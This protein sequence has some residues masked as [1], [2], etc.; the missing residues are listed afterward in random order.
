MVL[1]FAAG[2]P[3]FETLPLLT[4]PPGS[5]PDQPVATGKW[6]ATISKARIDITTPN[7]PKVV[8]LQL[9]TSLDEPYRTESERTVQTQSVSDKSFVTSDGLT[10]PGSEGCFRVYAVTATDNEAGSVTLIIKRPA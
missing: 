5:T 2:T 3:L 4:P 6:D 9:R 7:D 8:R 1:S 10:V